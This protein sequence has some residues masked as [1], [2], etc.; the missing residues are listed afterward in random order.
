MPKPKRKLTPAEK[1]AKAL[2]RAEFMTIF[3]HGKQ[4]RIRRP[5]PAE[6]SLDECLAKNADPV[7]LM[8]N[9]MWAELYAYEAARDQDAESL[10]ANDEVQWSTDQDHHHD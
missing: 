6:A 8:Q 5:G 9:E 1:R 3:V 7:W 4:K 2:R 10:P